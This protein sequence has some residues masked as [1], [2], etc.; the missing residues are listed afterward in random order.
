MHSDL[1]NVISKYLTEPVTDIHPL[2]GGHINSSYLV[3]TDTDKYVLQCLNSDL[4]TDHLTDLTNNYLQYKSACERACDPNDKWICPEW[5]KTENGQFFHTDI[6]GKTWRLY[7][8]IPGD[9]GAT[10]EPFTA[11][12]GLGK[13]HRL[14]RSCKEED[15]TPILPDLHNLKYYFDKYLA[16]GDVPKRDTALD[17]AINDNI[18]IM[19]ASSVSSDAVI[20]GDAKVSNMIIQN[21]TIV[22]FVDLDTLM[23][24]S[25]YDDLAD[26]IRSCC[27]SKNGEIDSD[28]VDR[29]LKGYEAFADMR[30]NSDMIEMV[31]KNVRKN[32][33]MLGLRYYTDHLTGNRYFAESYPGQNIEKA[34]RLLTLCTRIE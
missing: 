28:C 6:S 2:D 20:H 12:M 3:M 18:D 13:M 15:I 4:Y 23:P 14:L 24:G 7:H 17:K 33:F 22:S 27:I 5:L 21:D 1:I 26:C 9:T 25:L 31:I 11:G 29:L 10:A 16:I 8:Y 30:L 34:S 19:L 32:C